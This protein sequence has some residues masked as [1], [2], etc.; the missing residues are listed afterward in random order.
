[1]HADVCGSVAVTLSPDPGLEL[2]LYDT[3]GIATDQTIKQSMGFLPT[4]DGDRLRE[5]LIR[6]QLRM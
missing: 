1:M 6:S 2:G 3:L 4:L 5:K